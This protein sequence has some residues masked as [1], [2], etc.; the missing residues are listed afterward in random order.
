M[1]RQRQLLPSSLGGLD[2][3]SR[4]HFH[5]GRQKRDNTSAIKM[6]HQ[7]SVQAVVVALGLVLLSQISP[8]SCPFKRANQALIRVSVGGKI[9]RF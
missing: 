3:T 7:M 1:G 2:A 5:C 6:L 4:C 8:G 9:P